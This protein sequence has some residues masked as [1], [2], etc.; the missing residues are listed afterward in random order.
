MPLDEFIIAVFCC[1]ESLLQEVQHAYPGRQR[2]F[3]PRLADSEVLSMETVGECLG[4]DAEK[5]I[6]HYFRHH[7]NLSRLNHWLPG[8]ERTRT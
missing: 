2:G 1:I 7:L 4:I 8:C 5:Q 3:A 6:W